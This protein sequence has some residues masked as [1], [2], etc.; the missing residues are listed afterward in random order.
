MKRV[1][2][3]VSPKL[4]IYNH[5]KLP[6]AYELKEVCPNC[7]VNLTDRLLRS[8]GGG[9]TSV[10]CKIECDCDEEE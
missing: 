1:W 5:P 3:Q 9:I 4:W 10:G 8:G 2:H 6:S 7:E